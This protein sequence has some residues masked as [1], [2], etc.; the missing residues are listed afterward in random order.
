MNAIDKL[1]L[2]ADLDGSFCELNHGPGVPQGD[3]PA[4]NYLVVPIGY[5]DQSHTD[6]VVRELVIPVCHECAAALLG[7]EWTLFYCLDCGRSQWICRALAR[8]RYRHHI[9]WL[10]G[11][12]HCAE[13]LRGLSFNDFPAVDGKAEF[14]I[15]E[16]A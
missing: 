9:L 13:R 3:Y 6:I 16:A 10:H 14:L 1:G 7:E 4:C 2:L 11:C 5:R 12:P 15:P 8:L